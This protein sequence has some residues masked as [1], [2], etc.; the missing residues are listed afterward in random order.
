M[1]H[2]HNGFTFIEISLFIAI[3]G[4]VLVSVIGMASVTISQQRFNDV[5]QNFAEFLRK[6]YSEVENP[7]GIGDGRSTE[8][9]IYGKLVT[10]GEAVELDGATEVSEKQQR[11]F[12]YDV[13]GRDAGA[14]ATSM[15]DL[16]EDLNMDAVLI[17]KNSS[18]EDVVV[19]AGMA[20][21]YT[22][23]WGSVIDSEENGVPFKGSLLIVKNPRSG[24][25]TTLVAKG[26]SGVVQINQSLMNGTANVNFVRENSLIVNKLNLF[27]VEKLDFCVNMNGYGETSEMRQDVRIIEN[28]RSASGVSIIEMDGEENVCNE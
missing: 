3:S 22:P 18:N 13:V 24:M 28:A 15:K 4:L 1:R 26:D 11:I 21:S 20:E 27:N 10:F 19:R 17:Q 9:V 7:Q 16:I 5:T 6:V 12:V 25:I 23:R 8:Y 2:K 14:G